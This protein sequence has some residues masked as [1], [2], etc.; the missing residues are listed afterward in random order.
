MCGQNDDELAGRIGDPGYADPIAG[1]EHIE[2]GSLSFGDAVGM[3]VR[4]DAPPFIGG[5]RSIAR[6]EFSAVLR[7]DDATVLVPLPSGFSG[8]SRATIEGENM[9]CAR[10][11]TGVIAATGVLFIV[12]QGMAQAPAQIFACVNQQ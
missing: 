9:S 4:C 11:T 8:T 7:L 2:D 6:C 3:G 5:G 1:G 12:S 10:V